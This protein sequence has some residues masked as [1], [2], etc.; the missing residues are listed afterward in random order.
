MLL[1]AENHQN[2]RNSIHF[3][4]LQ[5]HFYVGAAVAIQIWFS[6]T[7]WPASVGTLSSRTAA[8]KDGVATTRSNCSTADSTEAVI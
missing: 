1:L 8:N 6:W 5:H 4:N 7:R 2:T 3:T